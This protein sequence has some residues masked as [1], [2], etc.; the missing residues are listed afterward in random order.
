[1]LSGL[2]R[3]RRRHERRRY[4]GAPTFWPRRIV[5]REI[6]QYSILRPR[7]KLPQVLGVLH[8]A[9]AAQPFLSIALLRGYQFVRMTSAAVCSNEF[10]T[11][12]N[13]K[14]GCRIDILCRNL[15][16]SEKNNREET[17]QMHRFAQ[18]TRIAMR[19]QALLR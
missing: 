14:S 1:M 7:V 8:P 3:V 9:Y 2:D 16:G 6:S 15:D 4:R 19:W 12:A 10:P 18:V 17:L 11:G 13:H 5:L